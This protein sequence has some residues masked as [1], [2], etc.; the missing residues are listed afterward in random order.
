MD[1]ILSDFVVWLYYF[2]IAL[3]FCDYL[4]DFLD[5]FEE[6]NEV[7]LKACLK[8]FKFYLNNENYESIQYKPSAP[9]RT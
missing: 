7:L 3:N 4:K 1:G 2:S 9:F 5:S 8:K 6:L